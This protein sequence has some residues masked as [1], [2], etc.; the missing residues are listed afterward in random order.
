ML[1]VLILRSFYDLYPSN[2]MDIRAEIGGTMG[3]TIFLR[4]TVYGSFS[5]CHLVCRAALVSGGSTKCFSIDKD[6]AE[7]RSRRAGPFRVS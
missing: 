2:V 3:V 5:W 4:S 7:A 1:I 6:E